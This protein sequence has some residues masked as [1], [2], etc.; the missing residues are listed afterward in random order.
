MTDAINAQ[1]KALDVRE[2]SEE[3][4]SSVSGGKHKIAKASPVLMAACATGMH[5]REATIT[6]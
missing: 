4:L 2:L 6:H 5:L 3:Q 1:S